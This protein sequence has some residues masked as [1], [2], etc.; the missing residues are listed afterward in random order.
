[1]NWA[2]LSSTFWFVQP[3]SGTVGKFNGRRRQLTVLI[4]TVPPALPCVDLGCVP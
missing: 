3:I 2:S 1:M 4:P